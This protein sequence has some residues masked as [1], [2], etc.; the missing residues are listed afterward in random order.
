MRYGA[1]IGGPSLVEVIP[2]AFPNVNTLI[3]AASFFFQLLWRWVSLGSG[4]SSVPSYS[5]WSTQCCTSQFWHV[6]SARCFP[7]RKEAGSRCACGKALVTHI[8]SFPCSSAKLCYHQIVR[9]NPWFLTPPFICQVHGEDTLSHGRGD[10]Y[11]DWGCNPDPFPNPNPNPNA[12][13][14]LNPNPNP[15]SVIHRRHCLRWGPIG[16]IK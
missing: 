8:N 11:V 12:T 6:Y 13:L 15:N 3:A 1:I 7:G 16:G 10:I 2:I 14:T 4:A 9:V 5:N